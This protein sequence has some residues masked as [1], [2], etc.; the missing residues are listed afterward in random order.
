MKSLPKILT[1]L[2]ILSAIVTQLF[3]QFE[4]PGLFYTKSVMS[5]LLFVLTVIYSF[6]IKNKIYKI[7]MAGYSLGVI[8]WYFQM[9]HWPGGNYLFFLSAISLAAFSLLMFLD[10]LNNEKNEQNSFYKMSMAFL[11]IVFIFD[12]ILGLIVHIAASV[13]LI[14]L[15]IAI[16]AKRIKFNEDQLIVT[17]L[18]FI[19][20]VLNL[21]S[22]S[23]LLFIK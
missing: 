3:R 2:I 22:K 19:L 11:T 7:C 4:I 23:G 9:N 6:R 5:G 12:M 18:I 20:A 14:G 17:H 10:G 1:F 16:K 13:A 15:I 8:G 21:I